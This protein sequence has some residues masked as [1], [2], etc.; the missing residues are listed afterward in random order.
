MA[1]KTEQKKIF[2][3]EEIDSRINGFAVVFTFVGA[4]L[5]LQFYPQYFGNEIINN[6]F[7]WLFIVVGISGFFIELTKIKSNIKG[8]DNILYGAIFLGIWFT[9]FLLLKNV[10]INIFTFLFMLLGI[11]TMTLGIQQLI[12]SI[13]WHKKEHSELK[14]V[15]KNK[16]DIV[17][18]LTKF[19]GLILVI[20]QI[21]KAIIDLKI[22]RG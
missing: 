2:F 18:F 20:V 10:L 6:A 5:F 12:Y 3:S 4:G 9:L 17:L 16:G 15:S 14:F 7:K 22:N 1:K 8:L 19:A 21:F 11:Y 13:I